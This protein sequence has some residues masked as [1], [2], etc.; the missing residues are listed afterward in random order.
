MLRLL[1]LGATILLALSAGVS[2]AG[3]P[4][5]GKQ[6]ALTCAACHG[7]DGQGINSTWP[8]L[9][10]QHAE[11]IR[12]QL[13]DFQQ[14]RRKNPQMT[15]MA[16]PLAE[17]DIAD[18]AAYFSSQTVKVGEADPALVATG[19]RI[20]RA[21]NSKTGLP[22][23]MACHGPD[24]SGNPAAAYPA[25]S[26]QFADYTAAQLMAFK[27]EQRGNDPA[28]VMRTIAS[29]MTNDDINAV[30]SYIQGLH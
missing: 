23:C 3:D 5:A 22:A 20:F 29:R 8:K 21:G 12:K 25:I 19:E 30:A 27:S 13:D 2:A 10:G 28:G 17:Q 4:A 6:T 24:G 9:A 7:P 18:V 15:P 16:M 11:Y 14:G 1:A 26:G